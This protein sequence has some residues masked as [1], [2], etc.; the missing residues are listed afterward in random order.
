MTGKNGLG[1]EGVTSKIRDTQS[2]LT[3]KD[4]SPQARDVYFQRLREMTPSERLGVLAALWE[5]GD[6][7]Q[8]AAVR[9]K[10]PEADEAEI[11]FRVAVSRFG[12]GLARKAYGRR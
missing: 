4:T 9:H 8:R 12:L 1:R 6:S 10:N 3:L 5:A 2:T 11:T 7:L